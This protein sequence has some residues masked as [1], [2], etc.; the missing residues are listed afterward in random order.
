MSGDSDPRDGCLPEHPDSASDHAMAFDRAFYER[1]FYTI[2]RVADLAERSEKTL[3]NICYEFGVPR[4]TWFVVRR[5]HRQKV[6]AVQPHVAEWLIRVTAGGEPK[7]P[8]G[9][10]RQ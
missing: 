3:R 8:G 1:P 6:V 5:R 4:R 7:K 9:W 2:R 10:M